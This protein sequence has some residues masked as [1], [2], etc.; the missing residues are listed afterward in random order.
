MLTTFNILF[1]RAK[2]SGKKVRCDIYEPPLVVHNYEKLCDKFISFMESL[3]RI[4]RA[5]NAHKAKQ[6]CATVL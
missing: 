3:S 2:A 5:N 1:F 6:V 4:R